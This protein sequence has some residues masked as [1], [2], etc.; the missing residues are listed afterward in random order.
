[1][2][3]FRK[4]RKLFRWV[5]IIWKLDDC[6]YC[7]LYTVIYS[8]LVDMQNEILKYYDIYPEGIKWAL[9]ME[10]AKKYLLLAL[11]EKNIKEAQKH[12]DRAFEIQKKYSQNWWV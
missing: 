8:Q 12:I 11:S 3:H 10:E 7:S 1:M 2:I 4:I 5:P 6:D 9:Q